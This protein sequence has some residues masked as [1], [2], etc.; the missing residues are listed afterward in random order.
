MEENQQKDDYISL[1]GQIK[2]I[3][4]MRRKLL[5]IV[6]VFVLLGAYLAIFT[7]TTYNTNVKFLS[8][9]SS[10][11]R[12]GGNWSGLAALVGINLNANAESGEIPPNIYP[13]IINS[14]PFQRKLMEIPL[15]FKGIDTAV[16]VRDY[17]LKVATPD[18]VTTLK[19]YTIGLPGQI[20][21]WI[22]GTPNEGGGKQKN[23][24]LVYLSRKEQKVTKILKENLMFSIDET[25]GVITITTIMPEAVPAAQLAQG[26]Q[27]LL[28]QAII[29]YR[30]GKAQDQMDFINKQLVL[31]EEN[32]K[33][34]QDR[35][36]RYKDRNRFNITESSQIELR[37]LQSEY[38]LAYSI[39]SELQRQ[40]V[41]QNIQVKKDTPIFTTINPASVPLEPAGP[42]R[43][44]IFIFT[45]ILGVIFATGFAILKQLYSSFKMQW[46]KA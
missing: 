42:N 23:D 3:W 43:I 28:Q 11:S 45:I 32:Y 1:L 46:K 2:G 34:I 5:P 39:Y 6:L 7:P 30:I 13:K 15:T 25:D 27:T 40:Q 18:G 44:A 20:S 21:K 8:Q 31:E 29:E 24:S 12:I 22:K 41:A 36:A 10:S 35:L 17:Y 38:D 26:A 16:T 9:T 19:K 4:A 37:R 14:I 33:N